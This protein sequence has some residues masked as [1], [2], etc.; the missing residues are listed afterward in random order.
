MC[1][2]IYVG[3]DV[4]EGAAP[5]ARRRLRAAGNRTGTVSRIFKA[6]IYFILSA[7]FVI[8]AI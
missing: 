2:W 1:I 7:N 5:A 3:K 6:N 8:F 4:P